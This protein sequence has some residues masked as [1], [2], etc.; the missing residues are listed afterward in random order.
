MAHQVVI[1]T[2]AQKDSLVGVEFAPDSYYN[3]IQDCNSNWVVSSEE[4][5]QTTDPTYDW[6]H[7]LTLVDFCAP[8]PPPFPPVV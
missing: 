1:L 4:V 2:E 6:L 8:P 3:P 7:S 5:N